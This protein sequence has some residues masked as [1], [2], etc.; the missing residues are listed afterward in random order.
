MNDK[1]LIDDAD[2]DEN[3]HSQ[4]KKYSTHLECVISEKKKAKNFFFIIINR[5]MLNKTKQ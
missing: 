2:D 1:L 3:I 4:M 5:I